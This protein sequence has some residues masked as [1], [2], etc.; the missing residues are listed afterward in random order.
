M[1]YRCEDPGS[2]CAGERLVRG[3]LRSF[4]G[5][6]AVAEQDGEGACQNLDWEMAVQILVTALGS[7]RPSWSLSYREM[8]MCERA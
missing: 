3:F 1:S 4:S 5:S 6:S 8:C 7:L 2:N